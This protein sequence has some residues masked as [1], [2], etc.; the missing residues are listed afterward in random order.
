MKKL[1]VLGLVLAFTAGCVTDSAQKQGTTYGSAGRVKGVETTGADTG[2]QKQGTAYGAAGGAAAGAVI[3]QIIG[4]NTKSTLL[5]A[6]IG[7]LI[8]GLIGNQY[9]KNV[10]ETIAEYN[11]KERTLDERI[12]YVAALNQSL[13][14]YNS[15]LEQKIAA[16]TNDYNREKIQAANLDEEYNMADNTLK[17]VNTEV[18]KLKKGTGTKKQKKTQEIAELDRK[19]KEL[20]QSKAELE[21]NMKEIAL[22][23]RGRL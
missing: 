14:D 12:N 10:D 4:R 7:A 1:A 22:I 20:E 2:A 19:I 9:G 8:G 18:A 11:Q 5:G 16:L 23:K 17:K 6:V 13:K 15:D 21:E 3:G